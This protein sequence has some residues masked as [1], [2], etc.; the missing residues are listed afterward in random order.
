VKNNQV[1]FQCRKCDHLLFVEKISNKK[2]KEIMNT[3]C[4]NCG[5]EGYGNW[6]LLRM[7]NYENEYGV[8]KNK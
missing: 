5:E 4:P 2:L 8:N 6:V 7:G 3:D 1:V